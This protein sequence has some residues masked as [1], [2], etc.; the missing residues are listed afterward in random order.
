MQKYADEHM[1]KH[2][3]VERG[4][5][6]FDGL[7][8]GYSL[9]T[10]KDYKDFEMFVDWRIVSV[11]GD[12][13][14]YLRGAPQ[15]QIW[16]PNQWKI[17]SGGLYNNQ[18]NPSK[19]LVIADNPIGQWNRFRIKMVGERVSVWL[20][21]ILVVDNTIMENYWN[22]RIPIYPSGQI[23]LQHHGSHLEFRNIYIKELK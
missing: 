13:G 8:G 12:S 22:R 20:N 4:V 10:K 16:D 18:K 6:R 23:E 19:A 11:Q 2:W 5:L 7:K 17:G 3:S 15:V 9:A 21:G 1:L 14:L